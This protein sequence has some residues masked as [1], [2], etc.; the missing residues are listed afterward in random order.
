M[1]QLENYRKVKLT[2]DL[3]W[4]NIFGVIILIPIALI[5]GIPYYF[6]WGNGFTKEGL[7]ESVASTSPWYFL[8]VVLFFMVGIVLHELIHGLTWARYT[9]HG[10]KSIK[11][12]VLWKMLTPYCHCK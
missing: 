1:E 7:K 2:I 10:F 3:V 5:Y 6:I 4:A 12:G 8:L 9:S 11:F